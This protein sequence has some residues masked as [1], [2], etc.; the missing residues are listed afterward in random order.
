V[1]Q[2]RLLPSKLHDTKDFHVVIFFYLTFIIYA[3]SA[4]L[5][6]TR[7][8]PSKFFLRVRLFC[9]VSSKNTCRLH[10]GTFISASK[11]HVK[12]SLVQVF[13][14]RRPLASCRCPA[15]ASQDYVRMSQCGMHVRA[16]ERNRTLRRWGGEPRNSGRNFKPLPRIRAGF[17]ERR[18]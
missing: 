9:H 14:C 15:T 13:S 7:E 11:R 6:F 4:V 10:L 1:R 3:R 5:S 18:E 17:L 12:Y 16:N 8:I 2:K